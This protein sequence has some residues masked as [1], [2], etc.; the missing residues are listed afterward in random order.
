MGSGI[1][2]CIHYS[3][4]TIQAIKV[5]SKIFVLHP[6]KEIIDELINFYKK[7]VVD[8]SIYY[9]NKENTPR[10]E[11]YKTISDVLISESKLSE[12][13]IG[14]IVHG[15]PLFLVS[16]SEYTSEQA[17]IN[18]VDVKI[19]PSISSFDT[20]LADLNLD[21]GY[22]LNLYDASIF[23][24]DFIEPN[25]N[26]PLLLFQIS[27]LNNFNVVKTTPNN[28]ILEPLI[29]KLLM[30]YSEEKIIYFIISSIDTISKPIKLEM[31][32]KDV[33]TTN[34]HLEKRPTIYIPSNTKY[35]H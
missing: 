9:E 31:K 20:I 26:V 17:I 8:C 24:R 22:A 21:F 15:H 6:D 25:P 19:L 27:T 35:I 16:A 23:M 4:E 2:S 3:I 33:L 12:K 5:C 11:I 29:E 30:Y 28:Q 10:S 13:P 32:L 34:L 7:E 1:K 18:N 14:F